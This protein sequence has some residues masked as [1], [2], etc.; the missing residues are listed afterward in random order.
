MRRVVWFAAGVGVGVAATRQ[1]ARSTSASVV[2]T[3][4]SGLATRV[5]R[6]VDGV[7]TDGRVEMHRREAR[8]RELLAV[9][10]RDGT[11]A[12]EGKR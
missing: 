4:A 10:G 12:E 1:V 5:R 2:G 9:P 8:L 6:V 7:V 3:V 11:G